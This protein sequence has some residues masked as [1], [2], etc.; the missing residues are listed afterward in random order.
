[1]IDIGMTK[2]R[3]QIDIF[4]LADDIKAMIDSIMG[5]EVDSDML[6]N[7]KTVN[8]DTINQA[9][10]T[11]DEMNQLLLKLAEIGK[12]HGIRFP[13]DFV[14]LTKQMLYFDRYM[15]VLAPDMDMFHDTN[16]KMV[17]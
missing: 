17:G 3:S 1:M 14:L 7:M 6:S 12:R 4:Q 9:N 2:D 15:Q 11:L 13:R 10:Q 8:S 5:V 16:I